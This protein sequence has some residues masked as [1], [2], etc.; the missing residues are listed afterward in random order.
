MCV[1]GNEKKNTQMAFSMILL[2]CAHIPHIY[3]CIGKK[4][5]REYIKMLKLAISGL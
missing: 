4:T 3:A 1:I 5:R 2:L